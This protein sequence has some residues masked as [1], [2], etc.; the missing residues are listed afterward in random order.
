MNSHFVSNCA[1]KLNRSW[2]RLAILPL[3]PLNLTVLAALLGGK[4]HLDE[5]KQ[6]IQEAQEKVA[7]HGLIYLYPQTLLYELLFKP[8]EGKYDEAEAVGEQ[9]SQFASSMNAPFLK[10]IARFFLGLNAYHQSRFDKAMNQ[11]TEAAKIFSLKNARSEF[12]IHWTALIKALLA[13]HTAPGESLSSQFEDAVCYYQH[14]SNHVFLAHA[15]FIQALLFHEEGRKEEVLEKLNQGFHMVKDK[16]YD[17]FFFL[18]WKDFT[19]VCILA[20]EFKSSEGI[21]CAE[22]FLA[23][24][25]SSWALPELQKLDIHPDPWIRKKAFEIRKNVHRSA[26]PMIQI[27]ALGGLRIDKEDGPVRES[28]WEGNQPKRLLKAIL[29]RGSKN[30]QKDFLIEDLWPEADPETVTKNFKVTLHRLRK[31]LEP[32]MDQT[33]GSSYVHLRDNL[34][35]LD[36]KRMKI[37]VD[38][39][40]KSIEFGK[41]KE[42][43]G[44]IDDA[45]K[46]YERAARY[47][48]GDFLADDLY[49]PWAEWRRQELQ[50]VYL[51]MLFRWARLYESNQ[52]NQKSH[53]RL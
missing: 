2:K 33:Y 53:F 49:A 6:M 34:I 3:K 36:D 38:G 30:I 17:H 13:T 15:R 23:T 8:L 44:D 26:V 46:W 18:S 11:V 16:G 50:D 19:R 24:R 51:S 42:R 52:E 4:G 21:A 41:E 20:I 5:A 9:L 27:A 43:Q 7:S 22:Q 31:A 25:L 37:D 14:T 47:Y 28:A 48:V 12:H 10:G 39:F 35:F 32:D 40:M 45:L 29:S 1:A